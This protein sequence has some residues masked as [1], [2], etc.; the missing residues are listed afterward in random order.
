MLCGIPVV[1]THSLGG[2]DAYYDDVTAIV[3]NSDPDEISKA[4]QAIKD[5]RID[6]FEIRNRAISVSD[7]MLNTL[8]YDILQPIFTRYQDPWGLNPREFVNRKIKDSQNKFSKGRT[9]FQ[10]EGGKYNS[11]RKII[12]AQRLTNPKKIQSSTKLIK[13]IKLIEA[14]S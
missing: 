11:L 6:P 13:K 10:P 5:R 8:A 14:K 1:S 4:V 9:I 12:Q 3:V 2:R 7:K